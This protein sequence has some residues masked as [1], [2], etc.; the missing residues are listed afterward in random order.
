MSP[1][2]SDDWCWGELVSAV[3]GMQERERLQGQRQAV[4][5]L[6]QA[7]LT[8]RAFG[9]GQMPEAWEVFPFWSEEEVRAARIEKYRRRMERHA[10]G[11]GP[12]EKKREEVNET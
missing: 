2:D 4:I 3:E 10:A 5:A 1:Q 9:G 12:T 11:R 6:G 8:A 7:Q